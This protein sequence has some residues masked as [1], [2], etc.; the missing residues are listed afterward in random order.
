MGS[1]LRP[2]TRTEEQYRQEVQQHI[3]DYAEFLQK[4]LRWEYSQRTIGLLKL[5]LVNPTDR[6]F[7]AVQVEVFLPGQVTAVDPDELSRPDS[8]PPARPRKFGTAPPIVGFGL[9]SILSSK[10][11]I[12]RAARI[13]TQRG[14]KIDNSGSA[15]VTYK[16]VTLR[17]RSREILDDI[18]LIIKDPPG[19]VIA[20]T[21]E[22]TATHAEAR[23][24]G[25]LAVKVATTALPVGDLLA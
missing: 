3:V 24:K 12:P 5:T 7:D 16:P 25:N 20:G 4:H 21:W 15:K 8:S 1:V 10:V 22:A 17:A 9:D 13:T 23:V 19:S 2:E 14:P 6:V 18:V 11:V